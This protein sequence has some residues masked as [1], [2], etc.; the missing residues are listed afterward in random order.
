MQAY[1]EA[2]I[3]ADHI[4]ADNVEGGVEEL[5]PLNNDDML[6]DV[7]MLSPNQAHLQIGFVRTQFFPFSDE[8]A[9]TQNF[10]KEGI[11]IWK[12]YFAPHIS[13]TLDCNKKK[14]FQIPVS[15]FNFITLMLVTPEKFDWA[16]N[17]LQSPLWNIIKEPIGTEKTVAFSIPDNCAV[18]EHVFIG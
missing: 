5:L 3:P 1:E 14:I 4:G 12:K 18:Q 6:E 10:S 15:W 7:G 11:A 8:S 13:G 16:K 2:D 9:V 17:F